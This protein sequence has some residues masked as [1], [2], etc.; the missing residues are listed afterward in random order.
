MHPIRGTSSPRAAARG[1]PVLLAW[2]LA[3]PALGQVSAAPGGGS[4]ASPDL[5]GLLRLATSPA[6]VPVGL[7][8]RRS[9]DL[10]APRGESWLVRRG[11]EPAWAAPDC[12]GARDPGGGVEPAGAAG[13]WATRIRAEAL[14][15]SMALHQ[16]SD[17]PRA[18]QDGLLWQGR[19]LSMLAAAGARASL[20]VLTVTALPLVAWQENADFSFVPAASPSYSPFANPWHTGRIDSPQRFGDRSF[21]TVSA[22][23]SSVRVDVRPVALGVST[24][25]LWWG[26]AARNPILMG[27][28]APGFPHLFLGT[29][30]PVDV[31]IGR[32]QAEVVWGWLR[33]SRYFDRVGGND[34]RQYS[35]LVLALSPDALPGFHLGAARSYL[36]R[37]PAGGLSAEDFLLGPFRSLDLNLEEN[38]L[39][40]LFA[41][42]APHGSG[43]EAYVEWAREDWWSTFDDFLQEPDHSQGYTLGLQQVVARGE[44]ALARV[45]GELTH[46]GTST[47]FRSG[48]P[49]VTF[50]T[51]SS[52]RQGYT[53]RGQLLGAPIG[54]G[55]DGQALGLD[56]LT[57]SWEAGLL[58]ERTRYDND[59]YYQRWAFLYDFRG[60]DVELGATLRGGTRWGPV[61]IHG[62]VGYL[63]RKNR[64]FV[65]HGDPS[66]TFF[67]LETNWSTIVEL[68]WRPDS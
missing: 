31:G 33:E 63:R 51:H 38:Q 6:P 40:S 9:L 18:A 8:W 42:F 32:L 62:S 45:H 21:W 10:L 50:Y 16:N 1:A 37:V 44:R 11:P 46:L 5:C 3:S 56:L 61:D 53:H 34:R 29:S 30:G 54:P 59:A 57:P 55:S 27:S 17:Y 22:G 64:G 15:A 66:K 7:D 43:F 41:R 12:G 19:G 52:V 39:A 28:S 60:H 47:S 20:G 26:P 13:P 4:T 49:Q 23:Q 48:R 67:P 68:A 36:A 25:N 65:E 35:G 58:L 24:E 14:P 2:L